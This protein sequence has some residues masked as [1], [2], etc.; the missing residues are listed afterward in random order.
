VSPKAIEVK[1]NKISSA[2]RAWRYKFPNLLDEL[3]NLV[4]D[5]ALALNSLKKHFPKHSEE[6]ELPEDVFEDQKKAAL[7]AARLCIVSFF[8]FL[9]KFNLEENTIERIFEVFV[10]NGIDE[11]KNHTGSN[12]SWIMK[13]F[14]VWSSHE[15]FHLLLAKCN[16]EKKLSPMEG[17]FELLA[18]NSAQFEVRKCLLSILLNLITPQEQFETREPGEVGEESEKLQYSEKFDAKPVV[19]SGIYKFETEGIAFFTRINSV[20][21]L[22]HL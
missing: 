17:I 9:P 13:L 21:R 16:L 11:M 19:C 20:F 2:I 5:L 15:R 22:I 7:K 8:T 4:C 12:I 6:D 14:L 18:A 10:W 1:I 3:L